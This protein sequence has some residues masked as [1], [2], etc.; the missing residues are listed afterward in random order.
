M[1]IELLLIYMSGSSPKKSSFT[2]LGL[3]ENCSKKQQAQFPGVGFG[4]DFSH[5]KPKAQATKDKRDKMESMKKK[6]N[7]GSKTTVNRVKR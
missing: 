2:G 3:L 4:K 5:I 7:H 6:K 1:A